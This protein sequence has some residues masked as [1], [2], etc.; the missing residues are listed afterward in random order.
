MSTRKVSQNCLA[1][2]D[3]LPNLVNSF[4]LVSSMQ[5][6]PN[7]DEKCTNAVQRLVDDEF[8]QQQ[9]KT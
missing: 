3:F 9:N 2:W 4:L 8:C 7:S 6:L 1:Q 5:H